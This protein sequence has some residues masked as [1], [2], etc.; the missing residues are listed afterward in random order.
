MLILPCYT[1]YCDPATLI[2][3]ASAPSR[4]DRLRLDLN[5]PPRK[6]V[7]PQQRQQQRQDSV[8]AQVDRSRKLALQRLQTMQ[9]QRQRQ[10]R[11]GAGFANVADDVV[12]EEEE[13]ED[14]S[15]NV[16]DDAEEER[17]QEDEETSEDDASETDAYS[18]LPIGGGRGDTALQQCPQG[19]TLCPVASRRPSNR[20]STSED[21]SDV[22]WGCFDTTTSVTN[23]GG[24]SHPHIAVPEHQAMGEDCLQP[25]SEA[26]EL[27]S[28]VMS[29]ACVQSRCRVCEYPFPRSYSS[30]PAMAIVHTS[31]HKLT[32][33]LLQSP[34]A[35]TQRSTVEQAHADRNLTLITPSSC[36]A[37]VSR[38][39][40]ATF[41][42]PLTTSSGG[43]LYRGLPQILL[44][45]PCN[46][47]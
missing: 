24:C 25:Q 29:A 21:P 36:S 42:A 31:F 12:E 27:A 16:S 26:D 34:A 19:F 39:L 47:L 22:D 23:C 8:T 20:D 41:Y 18:S 5:T 1:G 2:C 7:K 4:P 13:T 43:T 37:P 11:L 45:V 40:V 9:R 46:L 14:D 10:Q 15:N 28:G 44:V 17:S 3:A 35:Q 33:R 38:T 6:A 30:P 32:A